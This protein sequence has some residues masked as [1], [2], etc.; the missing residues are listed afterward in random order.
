M[1]NYKLAC[2]MTIEFTKQKEDEKVHQLL[3]GVGDGAFGTICYNILQMEPIPNLKK[4]YTVIIKVESHRNIVKTTKAEGKVWL[5]PP[6][7]LDKINFVVP[8]L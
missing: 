7:N 6:S 3:I 8:I 1:N 4:S 5:L 2:G